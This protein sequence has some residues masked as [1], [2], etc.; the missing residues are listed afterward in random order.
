MEFEPDTTNVAS[1]G[2]II[3]L[4]D[5][6]FEGDLFGNI[7]DHRFFIIVKFQLT[8]FEPVGRITEIHSDSSP[9]FPDFRFEQSV[10]A[11]W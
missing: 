5:G 10:N 3:V 8:G 11:H 6:H 4:F 2:G 1:I 9:L 7:E